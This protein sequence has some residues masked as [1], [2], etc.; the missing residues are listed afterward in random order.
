[1]KKFLFIYLLF[2]TF[3]YS[4]VEYKYDSKKT[5][6]PTGLKK[7]IPKHQIREKLN[8]YITTIIKKINLL[9]INTHNTIK[10]EAITIKRN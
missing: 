8:Y 9:R 4:Q 7:C 2:S 6:L 10:M 5:D 1:M 3:V